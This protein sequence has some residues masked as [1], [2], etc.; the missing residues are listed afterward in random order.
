MTNLSTKNAVIEAFANQVKVN[1]ENN[2]QNLDLEGFMAKGLTDLVKESINKIQANIISAIPEGYAVPK[3]SLY[4]TATGSDETAI[5]VISITVTNRVT[6]NKKFKFSYQ[7]KPGNTVQQIADFFLAIYT[8]L[9]VDAIIDENL[10]KV[11]SVL[12]EIAKEAGLDYEISVISPLGIKEGKKI[13]Y[14]GDDLI[15]FVA[16]EDRI[17]DTD[18]ILVLQEVS[19]TITEEHIAEAKKQLVEELGTAQTPEQLVGIHGGLLV[20]YIADINKR[21]RPITLIKS[22]CSRNAKKLTGN[23]DAIAYYSEGDV[24]A[25][26][27]KRDNKF[28]VVLSPFDINTLRKVDVDVIKAI[29][30]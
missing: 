7:A 27:A 22:V 15:Q 4:I 16:D 18:D 13:A 8:E 29:E 11:N 14:I 21:V 3:V 30:K 17:F 20:S 25:I 5:S 6:G 12:S 1:T 28:E 23:K 24:F 19:E 2:L 26:V 9:V 10:E